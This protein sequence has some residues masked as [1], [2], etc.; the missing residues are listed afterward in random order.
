MSAGS[1]KAARPESHWAGGGSTPTSAL[2]SL[3]VVPVLI[4]LANA[5]LVREHYLHST[6]GGTRLAFGVMCAGR[7]LGALTLGAGPKSAYRLVSGA[8]PPM[9]APL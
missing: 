9:T 6:P 2:Q 7:L 1:V 4:R 3:R 8:A 5:L